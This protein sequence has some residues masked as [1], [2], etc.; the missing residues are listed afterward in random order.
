MWEGAVLC[1]CVV[2]CSGTFCAVSYGACVRE[3]V[4]CCVNKED[5]GINASIL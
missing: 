2:S 3:G 1:C 5:V 4:S